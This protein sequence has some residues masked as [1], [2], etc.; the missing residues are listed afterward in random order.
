MQRSEWQIATDKIYSNQGEI[1][2]L[3]VL[4]EAVH[5]RRSA[6]GFTH[7]FS[8]LQMDSYGRACANAALDDMAN[9]LE[10]GD[11]SALKDDPQLLVYTTHLVM[12]LAKQLRDAKK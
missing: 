2:I 12:G 8:H 6:N 4:P 5:I 7:S 9:K 11:L 3:P 1:M 10:Q